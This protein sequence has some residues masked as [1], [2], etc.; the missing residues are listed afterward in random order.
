MGSLDTIPTRGEHLPFAER[1]T[2]ERM[3]RRR[4]QDPKPAKR[5]AWW[6]LRFRQDEIVNGKLTRVRKEVRLALIEKTSERDARRLATEHL[7]PLN[8]GLAGCGKIDAQRVFRSVV[9]R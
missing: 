9:H 3:A 5:G 8:Q 2:F 7:R 6:V 4:F 1:E